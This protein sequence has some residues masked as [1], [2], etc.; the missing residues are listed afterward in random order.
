MVSSAKGSVNSLY[1]LWGGGTSGAHT[2]TRIVKYN[3]VQAYRAQRSSC[4]PIQLVFPK[5]KPIAALNTEVIHS[6]HSAIWNQHILC[7]NVG[8]CIT[9]LIL[10]SDPLGGFSPKPLC[11]P[12]F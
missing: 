5:H 1:Y 2:Y 12:S 6:C 11:Q 3:L 8:N 7:S 9:C 4:I 10:W